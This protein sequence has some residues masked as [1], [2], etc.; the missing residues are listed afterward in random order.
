[1]FLI[2]K[3]LVL[4]SKKQYAYVIWKKKRYTIPSEHFLIYFFIHLNAI[5]HVL[6]RNSTYK[7]IYSSTKHYLLLIHTS[8][9]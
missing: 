7:L 1:M 6:T 9:I 4:Y 5:F 8:C 2:K 3:E